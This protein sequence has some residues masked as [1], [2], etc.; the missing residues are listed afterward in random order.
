MKVGV[1]LGNSGLKSVEV[2]VG[3]HSAVDHGMNHLEQTGQSG[4]TF[5]VTDD[6]LNG[7]HKQ[8]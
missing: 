2:Q 8:L 5:G 6:G 3:G 7:A 1:I 4:G